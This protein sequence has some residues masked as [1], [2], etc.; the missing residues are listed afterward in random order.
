MIKKIPENLK[1]FQILITQLLII[2]KRK[3]LHRLTVSGPAW[4]EFR[5]CHYILTTNKKM[6]KLKN[7]QLFLDP[8]E[9]LRSED[10]PLDPTLERQA[11]TENHNLAETSME[12]S[13][14]VWKPEL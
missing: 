14:T 8:S 9:K 6:N 10:K 13:A 11:D 4:R 5:S 2:Q 12:T 7:R 1:L 3:K